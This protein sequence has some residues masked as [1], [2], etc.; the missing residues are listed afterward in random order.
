MA[1]QGAQYPGMGRDLYDHSNEVREL[2]RTAGQ[3]TPFDLRAL[4]FDGS[5]EELQSTDKTQIAITVVNIA[6]ALVLHEH[7]ITPHWLAGFSL[8][9]YSAMML[10]G[11]LSIANACKAVRLRGE[12]MEDASRS[13]DSKEG[14]A[15][16]IAVLGLSNDEIKEALSTVNDEAYIAIE[17][18]PSQSVIGGTAEGLKAATQ[19]CEAAGALR[20]VRLRVSGPFHTPLMEE[21]RRHYEQGL[22]SIPF[23][24][25]T[26]P[27]FSNVTGA[28]VR[29]GEEARRL[30][31][32]QLVSPVRWIV[33]EQAI[34][35]ASAGN[36]RMAL[37]VGPGSVLRGLWKAYA[38]TQRDEEL[39]ACTAIGTVDEIKN[40]IAQNE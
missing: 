9:E 4:L 32:Q 31:I 37:D 34:T 28:N 21:A 24:N 29:N 2:F 1:G 14:A 13:L 23:A 30:A 10:A 19:A 38:K 18:S 17:N 7:G 5:A 15:G 6:T 25:P 40:L 16:L 12:C 39:P 8:G 3:H 22:K 36:K 33:E 20:I 27:I 35:A 11:V 26:T